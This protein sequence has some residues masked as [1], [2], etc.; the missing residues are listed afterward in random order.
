MVA[1]DGP[2]RR[3]VARCGAV[4]ECTTIERLKRV[5]VPLQFLD[6]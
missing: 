4:P 2:T 6:R 1:V 3:Q 5:E